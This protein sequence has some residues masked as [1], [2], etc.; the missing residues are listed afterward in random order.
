[1]LLIIVINLFVLKK[2]LWKR[3]AKRAKKK[4]TFEVTPHEDLKDDLEMNE[5]AVPVFD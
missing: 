2:I 5:L 4:V 1:M 3:F